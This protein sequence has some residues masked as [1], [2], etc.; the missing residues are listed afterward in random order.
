MKIHFLQVVITLLCL[1]FLASCGSGGTDSSL[2]PQAEAAI[3]N[4]AGI[5]NQVI[6]G[7]VSSMKAPLADPFNTGMIDEAWCVVLRQHYG[8]QQPIIN[9]VIVKRQGSVW[10]LWAAYQGKGTFEAYGCTN[11]VE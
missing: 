8:S 9:N 5:A 10:Q 11:H 3:Q 6:D 2:P 1:L 4:W 7:T